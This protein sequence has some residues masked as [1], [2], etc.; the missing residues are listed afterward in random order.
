MISAIYAV[1]PQ[2]YPARW[3]RRAPCAL[4]AARAQAAP[5]DASATAAHSRACGSLHTSTMSHPAA[6]P[7]R[8]A[9]RYRRHAWAPAMDRSSLKIRP[10][11]PSRAAQHVLKP[12]C[13]RI[14]PARA[15]NRRKDD[16]RRHDG[17]DAEAHQR[18]ERHEVVLL[19][20]RQRPLVDRDFCVRI[21]ADEAVPREMLADRGHPAVAQTAAERRGE[22][23]HRVR[24]AVQRA[25]A[26][27]R[28]AAVIEIEHRREA[29]VDAVR[30]EL[31]GDPGADAFRRR[32]CRRRV[33][34]PLLRRARASAAGR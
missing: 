11:N 24:I 29:E 8:R 21:R 30:G 27:D 22:M 6:A 34:I 13:A 17:L 28:A 26:D 3:P 7:P 23:R 9:P 18:A 4:R 19:Q 32:G 5:P 14:L 2:L 10:S 31:G 12:D 16:V 1:T 33:A 20:R 15:V 25:V